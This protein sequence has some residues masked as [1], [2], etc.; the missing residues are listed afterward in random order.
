MKDASLRFGDRQIR[1]ILEALPEGISGKKLE[2][3][4]KILNEW[5]DNDLKRSLFREDPA[6]AKGRVK[7]VQRIAKHAAGLLA[8]LDEFDLYKGE[9]WLVYELS[10]RISPM[11]FQDEASGQKQKLEDQRKLLREVE[12]V[13]NDLAGRFKRSVDQRQNIPAYRTMLDIAAIFEW[14]TNTKA[15]R[16]VERGTDSF[17]DFSRS[18]WPVIFEKGDDGLESA[19]KNWAKGTRDYGDGSALIVNIAWRYPTWGVFE[20]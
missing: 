12:L 16:R 14:L 11:G 15:I 2:L 19:L 7:P 3:L 13:A 9:S 20:P 8:A 10:K 1:L 5:F 4:P 6:V 18:I 17:G